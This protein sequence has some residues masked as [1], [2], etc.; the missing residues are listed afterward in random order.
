MGE[1]NI[2]VAI[3]LYELGIC[4]RQGRRYDEAETV[5]RHASTIQIATL[6]EDDLQVATTLHQLGVYARTNVMMRR[7]RCSG[8]FGN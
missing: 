3:T 2:Q 4:L 7:G 8:R 5:L 6:G 1:D